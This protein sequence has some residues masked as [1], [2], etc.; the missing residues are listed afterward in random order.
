MDN[1]VEIDLGH[2]IG[3]VLKKWWLVLLAAVLLGGATLLYTLYFI[4]PMY[5]TNISVYVKNVGDDVKR[6]DTINTAD[7]TAS[8][9]L[10]NTYVT[11]ITSNTVLDKVSANI[12]SI[13][14]TPDIRSMLSCAA[15]RDTEIFTVT[16]TN[17]NPEIAAYIANAVADVVTV[18]IPEFLEGSSV[19]IVDYAI[20]PLRPFTPDVPRNLIIGL[21]AGMFLSAFVIIVIDFF[22]KR[23]KS[24]EDLIR[25]SD[26]PVLGAV[27]DF[28]DSRKNSGNYGYGSRGKES[29]V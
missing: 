21:A 6:S 13:Y 29:A 10:V 22:D 12:G 24:E 1:F 14:A 8:Q 9:R 27:P 26:I 2:L 3:V 5:R 11:I 28:L 17:E 7:L 19:K 15:V 23:I 18:E 16:V 20:V 25:L 4:T